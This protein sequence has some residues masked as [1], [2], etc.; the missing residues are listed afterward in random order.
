MVVTHRAGEYRI[1]CDYCK[2]MIPKGQEDRYMRIDY[3]QET[4]VFCFCS[5]AHRNKWIDAKYQP[6]LFV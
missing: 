4:A 2:H 3:R 6:R 1:H 5:V